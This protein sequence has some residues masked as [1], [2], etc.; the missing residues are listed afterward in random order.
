MMSEPPLRLMSLSAPIQP[1]MRILLASGMLCLGAC[2]QAPTGNGPASSITSSEITPST[3]KPAPFVD[4]ED[5]AYEILA[6]AIARE[7]AADKLSGPYT[8]LETPTLKPFIGGDQPDA[9]LALRDKL[10][11]VESIGPELATQLIEAN[12]RPGRFANE[13]FP[14][15]MPVKVMTQAEN[16]EM[17]AGN[18]VEGWVRY[19]S[20]EFR[21]VYKISASRPAINKDGTRAVVML[22]L[23]EGHTFRAGFLVGRRIGN[24]WTVYREDA[25]PSAA[26]P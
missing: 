9:Y 21:G 19:Y 3:P 22:L 13:H 7:V 20:E 8:L 23:Q 16:D 6:L 2:D 5:V 24:S 26:S 17:F 14:P 12:R 15:E 11:K 18:E 10:A 25:A 4:A 1:S